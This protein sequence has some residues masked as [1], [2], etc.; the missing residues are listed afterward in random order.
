M[1]RWARIRSADG[2]V[3]T[4]VVG[5]SVLHPREALGSDAPAGR[6][7]SLD[8]ATW[9]APC[10][11]GKFI[12]LWNN[13]HAAAARNGWRIPA[14][15]LYL[16]KPPTALSGPGAVVR[17][18]PDVGRI[19]FEGE[20]GIVI[21]QRCHEAGPEEAAAAILGYTCINDLTAV[22]V[23]NAE[24]DF[25]QWTRAKGFDG[26]GVVGPVIVSGLDWRE[27][28]IRTLVNQR[29]RQNYPAADMIKSPAEIVSQLSWD[30]TLLP[31]DVI[32]CGTSLGT[33]PIKAGDQVD[34]VIDGI[35]TLTVTLAA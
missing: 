10:D 29:E 33:R 18:P 27:L 8:G 14:H 22:D 26:F 12:C 30:M 24:P 15:P 6:S 5:G 2:R 20:L 11:P 32:A 3:L 23:L 16:L 34:V 7:E 13:F 4:G 1:M 17:V 21:G 9:L 25:P 35:G 31:G 28:T 19:T